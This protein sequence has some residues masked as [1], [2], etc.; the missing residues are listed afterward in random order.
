MDE[1][2][3]DTG[4]LIGRSQYKSILKNRQVNKKHQ[5]THPDQFRRLKQ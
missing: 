4:Q 3:E 1:N 5:A 2:S